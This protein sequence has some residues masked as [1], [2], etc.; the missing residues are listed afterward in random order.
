MNSFV[1]V[2]E[3]QFHRTNKISL[4][5]LSKKDIN[6]EIARL[7]ASQTTIS[8]FHKS[9]SIYRNAKPPMAASTNA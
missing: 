3:A 4:G 2:Q 6:I 7:K 8:P 1:N 9:F 5:I